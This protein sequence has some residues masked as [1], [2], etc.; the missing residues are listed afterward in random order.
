MTNISQQQPINI[1][2]PLLLSADKG[3]LSSV[4]NGQNLI[5]VIFHVFFKLTKVRYLK[6]FAIMLPFVHFGKQCRV[7]K[8]RL[9]LFLF[10]TV[11]GCI[12]I[13][14]N[15]TPPMLKNQYRRKS[16]KQCFSF[17]SV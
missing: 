8:Y 2:K 15:P 6:Q 4:L 5:S 11:L 10:K 3:S 13:I 9:S 14:A 16:L 1:L 17:N 7:I 12:E